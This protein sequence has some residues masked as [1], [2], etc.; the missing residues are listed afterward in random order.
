MYSS[1]YLESFDSTEEF[2]I[3]VTVLIRADL[4]PGI[5]EFYPLPHGPLPAS[6]P[7]N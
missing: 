2:L 3:Y 1:D 6:F 5:S 7:P 4:L